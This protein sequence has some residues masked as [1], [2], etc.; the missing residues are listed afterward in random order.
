MGADTVKIIEPLKETY[1]IIEDY[2]KLVKN[3]LPECK[4]TL[5]GSFAVPMCGKKE[6]DLVVEI[7]RDIK[8]S[9]MKIAENSNGKIGAGPIVDG[10]GYCRS[11]KRFGIICKL[12][13]MPFGHKKKKMCLKLIKKL[14]DNPA[15]LD[16]YKKLKYSL[17]GKSEKLYRKKKGKFI[18]DNDLV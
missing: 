7:D 8:E 1:S 15:L 14:Q 4:I 13:V 3:A 5:I 11:K 10:V 6:F 18:L 2:K 17:N 9:Q 16:E 12:H